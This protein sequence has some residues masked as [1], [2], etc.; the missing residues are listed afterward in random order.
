M[1]KSI[2]QSTHR[3]MNDLDLVLLSIIELQYIEANF[4]ISNDEIEELKNLHRKRNHL[5]IQL[6]PF[7][8]K[9]LR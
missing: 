6:K 2:K 7:Q 9:E 5:Q 8:L 3:L 4:G 1:G